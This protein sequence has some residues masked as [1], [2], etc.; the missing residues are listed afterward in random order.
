MNNPARSEISIPGG[1]SKRPRQGRQILCQTMI[2]GIVGCLLVGNVAA[3][4]DITLTNHDG[5]MDNAYAWVYSGNETTEQGS[6]AECF[7]GDFT[8][9][10]LQVHLS[11]VGNTNGSLPN[12][13]FDVFVWQGDGTGNP[14]EVIS[15]IQSVDPGLISQWPSFSRHDINLSVPVSGSWWVGVR[16]NESPSAATWLVAADETGPAGCSRANIGPGQGYPLGWSLASQVAFMS[17]CSSLG[18]Q[19]VGTQSDIEDPPSCGTVLANHDLTLES[20]YSWVPNGSETGQEGAF[21]ECFQVPEDNFFQACALEFYFTQTGNQGNQTMDVYVWENSPISTPGD[22]ILHLENIDPGTVATWPEISRFDLPVEISISSDWWVGW[23]GNWTGAEAGWMIAGDENGPGGCSL[24]NI[25]P[26]HGYPRG[27]NPLA[28]VPAW[29]QCQS[30]G[31]RTVGALIPVVTE[32][33]TWDSL[34][35]LYR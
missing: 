13:T 35:S 9:C 23:R 5:T 20:A 1:G 29:A 34:K 14:G 3:Q 27:W 17:N 6:F 19:V 7:T 31:I 30:L 25:G 11:Q 8:I 15:H 32:S 33:I 2:L 16:R 24:T 28:V 18:I 12:Q 26:G 4:C 10:Q 21:A 22:L